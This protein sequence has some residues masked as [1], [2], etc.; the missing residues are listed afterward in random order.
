MLAHGAHC[1]RRARVGDHARVEARAVAADLLVPALII[2]TA[3]RGRR[4][5]YNGLGLVATR[6]TL[7]TVTMI[8]TID[9]LLSGLSVR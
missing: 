7:G 4:G 5:R 1:A 9:M 3:S 6:D 2:R 8:W